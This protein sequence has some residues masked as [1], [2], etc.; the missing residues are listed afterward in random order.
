MRIARRTFARGTTPVRTCFHDSTFCCTSFCEIASGIVV[1]AT[2]ARCCGAGLLLSVLGLLPCSLVRCEQ[3]QPARGLLLRQARAIRCE[4]LW[5]IRRR[6]LDLSRVRY[7]PFSLVLLSAL[8][9]SACVC[10][11]FVVAR[12]RFAIHLSCCAFE[13]LNRTSRWA[14]KDG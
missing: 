12:S 3:R 8:Q 4:K 14:S 1:D 7:A 5:A 9:F 13:M 10:A 6:F 11:Q 2:L